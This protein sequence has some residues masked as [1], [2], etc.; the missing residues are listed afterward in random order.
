MSR[1]LGNRLPPALAALLDGE[2]L[3]AKAGLVFLLVSQDETGYPHPAMLSVGEV[4]AP[5]PG[6]LRLA[7]YS[8]S[9]TTRNLRAREKLTLALANGGFGYYVKATATET[10]A[11]APDLAGLAVFEATVE[12]VLEDGEPVARVMSGF[13]MALAGDPARTLAMWEATVSALRALG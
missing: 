6:R 3:G 13:T 7:L 1:S 5:D 8:S 2:Q 12:D 10:A 4:F 9:T 11:T